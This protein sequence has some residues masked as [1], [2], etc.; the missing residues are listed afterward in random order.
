MST[1]NGKIAVV[2]GGG[3]GIGLA[4]AKRLAEL[5]ATPILMAR[6]LERLQEAAGQIPGARAIAL[7]VTSDDSVREAFKEAG[8]V[9]ILVNNAGIAASSPFLKTS[10]EEWRRIQAVNVEGVFR[11]TQAVL[12]DMIGGEY[13][14]IVNIASIAGLR[15]G[16]YIAAYN[17]SKHALIGM[18]RSLA[19]EFARTGLTVNAVCPGY[20]DTP[21]AG[22]AI[23][24][25]MEK[26]GRSREEA[27]GVLA[28]TNP[29]KRLIPTQDIA[30]A[31]AYF[32]M[33]AAGSTNGETIA[34]N[35]GQV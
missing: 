15:G 21:M 24:T 19:A 27:I 5:G 11:C 4:T 26:T 12:P 1:L 17:A 28:E 8:R 2:T 3:T 29:Q 22:Q 10:L 13:A 7:D 9:D 20:V 34:V 33:P 23:D 18:T 35:G 25:I 16:M 6:N 32:C 31:V 30:E 14:R